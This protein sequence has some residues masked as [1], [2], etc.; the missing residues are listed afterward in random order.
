MNPYDNQR[1]VQRRHLLSVGN[2]CDGAAECI[3]LR[4]DNHGSFTPVS[5]EVH[6]KYADCEWL[7]DTLTR[8]LRERKA[9]RNEEAKDG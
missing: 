3:E 7:I 9:E 8:A 4:V 5:C 6:L 1:L 2:E